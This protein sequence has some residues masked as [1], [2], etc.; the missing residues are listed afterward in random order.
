MGQSRSVIRTIAILIGVLTILIAPL[1]L[2]YGEYVV[3]RQ[4]ELTSHNLRTL[5]GSAAD[6]RSTLDSQEQVVKT[7]GQTLKAL[8]QEK[9]PDPNK[10]TQALG[11]GRGRL[12]S[13]WVAKG[14]V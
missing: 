1:V 10:T 14:P 12:R 2:F 11:S 4:N 5:A 6:F 13:R 7:W 8:G 9:N 3:H